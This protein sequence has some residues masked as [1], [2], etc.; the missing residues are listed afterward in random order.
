MKKILLVILVC[1]LQA[2]D[3]ISE[4]SFITHK[5]YGKQLYSYPRGGIGCIKC[6]GE[7][8][9]G[10][11]IAKYIE[12]GKEKILKAPNISNLDFESFVKGTKKDSGVMPKYYLTNEEIEAIYDYITEVIAV[13]S[14]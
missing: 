10:L 11:E 12:N 6:H 13:D 9:D 8:G 1:L 14:K 5:E 2:S 3:H 4:D 7:S